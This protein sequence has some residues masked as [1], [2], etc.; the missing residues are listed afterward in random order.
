[1]GKAELVRGLFINQSDVTC[2]QKNI[3]VLTVVW[4]YYKSLFVDISQVSVDPNFT[5]CLSENNHESRL[6]VSG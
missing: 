6:G 3:L 4:I 5:R 2:T 1:M